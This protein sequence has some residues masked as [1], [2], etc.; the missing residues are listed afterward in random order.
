MQAGT[1]KSP[2]QVSMNQVTIQ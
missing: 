1:N 2:F